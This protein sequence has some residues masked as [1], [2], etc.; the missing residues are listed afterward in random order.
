ML[1]LVTAQ[2]WA[3]TIKDDATG[4]DCASVGV[5][6]AETKTCTLTSDLTEG[7]TVTSSG[8]TID[9]AG[10]TLNGPGN[11]DGVYLS[12]RVGVTVKNLNIMNFGYCLRMTGNSRNNLVEGNTFSNS[13][14]GVLL[15]DSP[16][17]VVRDNTFHNNLNCLV[18]QHGSKNIL[19]NN[20][21]EN[22]SVGIYSG[23]GTSHLINHN[24]VRYNNYGVQLGSYQYSSDTS[25][26]IV[27]N[28]ITG[29][30]FGIY[31][32]YATKNMFY[33]NNLI[34]NTRQAYVFE[35]AVNSFNMEVPEGGNFWSDWTS[36][37]ADMDGFVDSPYVFS[38]GQDNLPWTQIDGWE[39]Q[40]RDG[41]GYY[42]PEDCNDNDPEINPG[43][44]EICDGT[45][46]NCD[47][48]I[49]GLE[50]SCGEGVCLG[51]S[52][53]EGGSWSDCSSK[54]T[55]AGICA[56]CDSEGVPEYDETQTGD[57]LPTSCP[58]SGCGV[59]GCGE[60]VFGEYPAYVENEC[61][62]I[63]TCTQNIC[64][65]EVICE[66][67]S[68]GDG[69][70]PSCGDCDDSQVAINLGA[71]EIC[72]QLDNNCDGQTDNVDAD[73][74]GVNDCTDDLCLGTRT[75]G[76]A[77]K[78]L[79]PWH[80]ADTDNDGVFEVHLGWKKGLLDS[81]YTL[82][83][84]HGCT[85]EQI[86]SCFPGENKVLMAVGC[87]QGILKMWIQQIG[88]AKTCNFNWRLCNS[89]HGNG[90]KYCQTFNDK[91]NKK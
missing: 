56:V 3:L 26:T 75:E 80:Y 57:C 32:K 58:E 31:I 70:S 69:Y 13:P 82:E 14:Y 33:H 8:V 65:E 35:N 34:D 73:R 18:T 17:N 6:D 77:W 51:T 67:D 28:T 60:F 16:N 38:G 45:D 19:E 66:A 78:A 41:D 4:G 37:D 43:A 11:G 83:D 22:C 40:D 63:Y 68:D 9:G 85:C 25:H 2:G 59:A 5:W 89:E 15:Y 71:E 81:E 87:P 91:G 84:T 74:D 36:P 7:I 29:N 55:D 64:E 50:R 23:Y 53:C 72:D 48:V 21:I 1:V 30:Q 39:I 49:D 76:A 61:S 62:G 42:P 12:A 44:T 24:T 52:V 86:L 46:N 90:N 47:G 88:W 20:L 54:G 10:Y 79:L 27:N